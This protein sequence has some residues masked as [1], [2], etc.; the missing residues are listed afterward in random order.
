MA[1]TNATRRT[2]AAAREAALVSRRAKLDEARANLRDLNNFFDAAHQLTSVDLWL[3]SKLA[4]L[5]ARA[6]AQRTECRAKA[7]AALADMRDRGLTVGEIARISGMPE[8]T[9]RGYMD[10]TS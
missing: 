2:R 9:L 6:E 1:Y 7:G 10:E 3:D 4:D 8:E 5:H